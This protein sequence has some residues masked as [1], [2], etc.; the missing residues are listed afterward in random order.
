[1]AIYLKDENGIQKGW[2]MIAS[3]HFIIVYKRNM[4]AV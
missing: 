3:P 2:Q 1:M 4:G